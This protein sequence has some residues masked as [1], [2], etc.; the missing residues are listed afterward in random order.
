MAVSKVG[1]SSGKKCIEKDS[2]FFVDGELVS[3][4]HL[5]SEL[6]IHHLVITS[7][8]STD[9]ASVAKS[10]YVLIRPKQISCSDY[11]SEFCAKAKVGLQKP[12]GVHSR[13]SGL[14]HFPIYNCARVSVLSDNVPEG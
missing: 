6:E 4:M 1:I 5:Q 10:R 11:F 8:V 3:W 14:S 12:M 7:I 9:G 2:Y 13:I